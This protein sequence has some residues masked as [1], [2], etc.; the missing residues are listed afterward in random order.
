MKKYKEFEKVNLGCSDIA[1]LTI[2]TASGVGTIDFYEDGSYQ[3]YL[4]TEK[5]EI[6]G[7]YKKVA[8][9]RTWLTV[10]DDEEKTVDIRTVYKAPIEIYRAGDFGCI[11]YLPD[12]VE[13]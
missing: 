10:F 6:P 13:K 8:E 5:I 9:G 4:V 11:I 1:S 3:A 2:R 12:G 7:H